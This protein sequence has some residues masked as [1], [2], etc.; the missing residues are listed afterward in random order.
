MYPNNMPLTE[1][2]SIDTHSHKLV[3]EKVIK[4]DRIELFSH[5]KLYDFYSYIHFSKHI[6][7]D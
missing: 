7:S 2:M 6:M 5:T 1:L 4:S 3:R